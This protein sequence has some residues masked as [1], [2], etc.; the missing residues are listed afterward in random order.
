MFDDSRVW[1]LFIVV[2]SELLDPVKVL[3]SLNLGSLELFNDIT[4]VH[5]SGNQSD[6]DA[7]LKFSQVGPD[8]VNQVVNL[9]DLALEP[10]LEGKWVRLHL[11]DVFLRVSAPLNL[12]DGSDNLTWMDQDPVLTAVV[13]VSLVTFLELL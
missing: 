7:T 4:S 9:L 3:G 11:T 5:I 6:N 12:S 8:V 10:S 1:C 2:V 13:S